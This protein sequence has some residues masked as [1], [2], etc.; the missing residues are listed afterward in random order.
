MFVFF[1]VVSIIKFIGV[2]SVQYNNWSDLGKREMLKSEC[3]FV[4]C[5]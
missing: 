1:L 4:F 2:L 5:D 3:I